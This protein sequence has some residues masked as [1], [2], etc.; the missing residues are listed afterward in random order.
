MAR[1]PF[2]AG[3]VLDAGQQGWE[4]TDA[5]INGILQRRTNVQA[6]RQL[7]GGDRTGAASTFASSGMIPE[8]RQMTSDQAGLDNT[9]YEHGRQATQDADAATEKRVSTLKQ[10]TAGLRN[11]PAGQRL[12]QLHTVL[13]IFEKLG[14]D[15]TPFANLTEDQL[16]DQNLSA[17]DGEVD[18]LITVNRGGGGYDVVN[19]RTGGLVR[20]VEPTQRA[21]AGF[22]YGPDG[23]LEVDPG[24]VAGK[25]QI[26]GATRAPPR[27]RS[28]GVGGSAG[29]PSGFVLD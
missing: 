10:I 18:K 3:S 19:Q 20:S 23:G 17:F 29:V 21:P 7:A 6:G 16:T 14:M 22:T 4:D 11:V 25:R 13:P 12:Q 1:N 2:A 5:R 26:A 28:G 24:Y 27:A 15:P 9:A 8:S